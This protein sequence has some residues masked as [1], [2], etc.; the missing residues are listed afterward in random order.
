MLLKGTNPKT[1]MLQL[2]HKKNETTYR[3]LQLSKE[4]NKRIY[5][6]YF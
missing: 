6:K 3:Y 2:G 5:K 1:V 4:N